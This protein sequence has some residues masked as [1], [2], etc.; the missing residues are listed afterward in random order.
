MLRLSGGLRRFRT[1]FAGLA[2]CTAMASGA[3]AAV[4]L[5]HTARLALDI[6]D[7]SATG[8]DLGFEDASGP[9]LISGIE[10]VVSAVADAETSP[11]EITR[12]EVQSCTDGAFGAPTL[13]SPGTWPV[14]Q[15]TGIDAADVVEFA[16]PTSLL[17]GGST[18]RIFAATE[19]AA[20]GRDALIT[21]NGTVFGSPIR[22]QIPLAVP[23]LGWAGAGAMMALLLALGMA[24]TRTRQAR[25]VGLV[26]I[27]FITLRSAS[28][29][30]GTLDGQVNDWAGVSPVAQ[31]MLGD[32]AAG[33]SQSDLLALF[34][35]P[36]PQTLNVRVDVGGI[37]RPLDYTEFT[38]IADAASL[39]ATI[40][41]GTNTW[42]YLD[43]LTRDYEIDN[44]VQ[45]NL[46]G[47]HWAIHGG[48]M[49]STFIEPTDPDADLFVISGTGSIS[50]TGVRL[51]N[52]P[53]T[54][55]DKKCL[56]LLNDGEKRIEANHVS[57]VG[58]SVVVES[59]GVG[60]FQ[61]YQIRPRSDT[62]TIQVN[63][64]EAF[65]IDHPLA[66]ITFLSVETTANNASLAPEIDCGAAG[67]ACARWHQK[68]G[69]LRVLN[70]SLQAHY[71][72]AF[73]R[74]DS[75]SA[76][77][78]HVIAASRSEGANDYAN[79]L[80]RPHTIAYVPDGA[81]VDLALLG[82]SEAQNSNPNGCQIVDWNGSGG[83]LWLVGV[84]SDCVGASL[85]SGTATGG[86]IQ[87]ILNSN[88]DTGAGYFS[89]TGA[90]V[91]SAHNL[92]G[93]P[94]N[95]GWLNASARMADWG[96]GWDLPALSWPGSL[97]RPVVSAPLPE[98]V[99]IASYGAI[100]DDTQ[101]DSH[102]FQA[103]LDDHCGT[104]GQP[105]MIYCPDGEYNINERSLAFTHTNFGSACARRPAGGWFAGR[106]CRLHREASDKDAVFRYGSHSSYFQGWQFI[107]RAF[108]ESE[109]DPISQP[110]FASERGGGYS[111][112]LVVF[113]DVTFEGGVAAACFGC[114]SDGNNSEMLAVRSSFKNSSCGWC[115]GNPNAL[116]NMALD[117]TFENNLVHMG[118]LALWDTQ[119]G[120]LLS[121]GG[122][123]VNGSLRATLKGSRGYDLSGAPRYSF[124]HHGLVSDG[125]RITGKG[126]GF[127][128]GASIRIYDQAKFSSL[129]AASLLHDNPPGG[130]I[131]IDSTLNQFDPTLRDNSIAVLAI[132]SETPDAYRASTIEERILNNLPD[133]WLLRIEHVPPYVPPSPHVS[134]GIRMG[135]H[136]AAPGDSATAV[137]Q[138]E[139]D[140]SGD[141]AVW[142]DCDDGAGEQ[143]HGFH[144]PG[145]TGSTV[146]H[147]VCTFTKAGAYRVRAR[148]QREGVED[149]DVQ[150]LR[151]EPAGRDSLALSVAPTAGTLGQYLGSEISA[152]L[153][154]DP[155]GEYDV[156]YYCRKSCDG[157]TSPLALCAGNSDC[158]GFGAC[159]AQGTCRG[160]ADDGLPCHA[161][162][163]CSVDA[164]TLHKHCEADFVHFR[165]TGDSWTTEPS[166]VDVCDAIYNEA[167][168]TYTP[169]VLVRYPSIQNAMKDV[170]NVRTVD[171]AEAGPIAI[172]APQ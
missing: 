139:G 54:S 14:G 24:L 148:V 42:L 50:F 164:N 118:E 156:H 79:S 80:N 166:D 130:D 65:V 73:F 47:K 168:G 111:P 51:G 63:L 90:Q 18:L 27:A 81:V 23:S 169:H 171:T 116:N 1:F 105:P 15:G 107:T 95:R 150:L 135:Q 36:D 74:F 99:S 39:K 21:T 142:I 85:V 123:K 3:A 167:A 37:E 88:D 146:L 57:Q 43:H 97:K 49:G 62:G 157:G 145:N 162:T 41:A 6:D 10:R 26:A 59:P 104:G 68:E 106:S 122:G 40:Q 89:V 101:D 69:R 13:V 5:E 29:L 28:A 94:H 112:Q 64:H 34:V 117:S 153:T 110:A 30:V 137:L 67:M 131:F 163:D 20:G 25:A 147:N 38:H 133:P 159:R 22:I 125:A 31:E 98:M 172:Q 102:A 66:D 70:G 52:Y 53:A 160:G 108:D 151:V 76:L 83:R 93:D 44:P 121:N 136:Q 32:S 55:I 46:D 120:A 17:G 84:I 158:T 143:S 128:S 86:R 124:Y 165:A 92:I 45:I 132:R 140:A 87:A 114:A 71:G 96:D 60:V 113:Q 155:T 154:N 11:L 75:T 4:P 126:I 152:T 7:D 61:G 141:V 8:C 127:T 134:V 170:L 91:L 58:C 138:I 78:P 149:A 144:V 161:D 119:S 109:L 82:V 103:A 129:G 2:A 12:V 9:T 35:A 72:R 100:P 19:S 33:G 115:S 77:G 56:H 48:S 16:V